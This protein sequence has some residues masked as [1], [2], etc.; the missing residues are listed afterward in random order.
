[1]I[2]VKPRVLKEL[3]TEI[4]PI[5]ALIFQI[6]RESGVVPS[7]W[8]TAQSFTTFALGMGSVINLPSCFN[9]EIP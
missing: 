8:K 4:V 5:L 6:S 2:F 7:D 9:D 3:D 1:M